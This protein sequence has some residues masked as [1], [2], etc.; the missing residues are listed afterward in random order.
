[1]LKL[2]DKEI[3]AFDVEWVPDPLSG[4]LTYG[5]DPAWNDEQ[6]LAEMWRHGGATEAD[7][8][9]YLKTVLCRV[10]SIAVVIRKR[11][12]DGSINLRLHSLPTHDDEPLAE[13]DILDR[14]LGKLGTARPQLVGYNSSSADLPILCQRAIV[15]GLRQP[16]FC[17]RPAKPWEGIDYFAKASD[18]HVDLKD[19]IG[20][21][22]KGTPKLH[23]I[24]TASGI[25]GKLGTDGASV[26]DLWRAGR[27]REIVQYNEFDA[28]TTYLLWLR[29]AH[30]SGFVSSEDY[31][32][33]EQ[34]LAMLLR[35]RGADVADSHL[36]L[37]LEQW[38]RLKELRAGGGRFVAGGAPTRESV[39]ADAAA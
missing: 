26:V 6:V 33:E 20:A 37:Y 23:E 27:V 24:A 19:L 25:P 13:R 9:P 11:L 22:G 35:T 7:P 38:E 39:H 2:V 18:H 4:R 21:W 5:C 10:V 30:F 17:R 34:Q 14:F 36:R 32:A 16:E 31:A 1:M 29:T 15:N 8:R 12:P 3:W 28:L